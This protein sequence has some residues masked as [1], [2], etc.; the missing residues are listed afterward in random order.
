MEDERL[1][2]KCK[3]HGQDWVKISSYLPGH[4]ESACRDRFIN[5]TNDSLKGA[6]SEEEGKQLLRWHGIYGSNWS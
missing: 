4:S 6:W 5:L 1:L 2:K 3:E